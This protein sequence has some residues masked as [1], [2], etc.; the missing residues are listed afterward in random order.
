[1]TDNPTIPITPPAAASQPEPAAGVAGFAE[2]A[3]AGEP[4]ALDLIFAPGKPAIPVT[5][6]D[7][8]GLGDCTITIGANGEI[9]SIAK[10]SASAVVVPP[11]QSNT[12]N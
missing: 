11:M 9:I 5:S 10:G 1:V 8:T 12:E 3:P 4:S 6:I 2:P 7:L